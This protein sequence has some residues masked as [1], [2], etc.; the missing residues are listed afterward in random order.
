MSPVHVQQSSK[1]VRWDL[2]GQFVVAKE[3][4]VF[5]A[6]SDSIAMMQLAKVRVQA[7]T[8]RK[9]ISTFPRKGE[10]RPVVITEA[11]VLAG[12]PGS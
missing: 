4:I 5:V 11:E 1:A 10:L 9:Q 8:P 7:A 12:T 6:F 3:E 2:E